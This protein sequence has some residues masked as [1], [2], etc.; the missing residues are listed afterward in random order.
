[1]LD[2]YILKPLLTRRAFIKPY[3]IVLNNLFKKILGNSTNI[4]FLAL[5]F[6]DDFNIFHF[7]LL[8]LFIQWPY[9]FHD[10]NVTRRIYYNLY[11]F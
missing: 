1:M 10:T 5:S 2:G 8:Q 11:K 9:L 3:N 7:L 6:L 4:P